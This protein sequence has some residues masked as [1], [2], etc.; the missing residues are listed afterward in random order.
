MLT[1][2]TG[3]RVSWA[4]L[5]ATATVVVLGSLHAAEP[6][7]RTPAP[8]DLYGD[9][10]PP[11]ALKRLGTLRFRYAATAIAYSPDG[12]LLA[13][14][15]ADNQIRLFDAATGRETRRLAG[16]QARTFSPVQDKKGAFDLLVGSVGKGHVTT[17]A[18]AP[19]G[20]TLASGAWDETIRLWDVDSG[21]ELRRLDGHADGMVATVTFSTDSKTLASRGGN[22][23]TV[24]LWEVATGK[25]L[26]VISKVQRVNPWRFNRDAALAFAPDG[27]TLAVG[28]AKVIQFLDVATGKV[29]A[30][31]DAH[32]GCTCLAYSADGKLLASGGVDGNDKHS[33][34]IWDVESG[35]ELR[36]CALVKDEPPISI[37]FS[38]DGRSLAAVVEEDQMT[39]FDV[40][41]GKP[42]RRLPQYWPSRLAYSPDGKTLA[43][44]GGATIRL[45]DPGTGKERGL[46]FEGH[47]AGVS[48]LALA[49]D[50][51]LIVSG[52]ENVRLWDP[53]TGKLVRT[54]PA[55]GAAIAL[56]PDG[57]T[58]ATAG[59]DRLVHLWDVGTGKETRQLTG[60]KHQLKGVAFSPDGNVLA[61]AD[62]QATVRLWDVAA[63]K[64]L[65]V[66][67]MKSLAETLSFAFSPDGKALACAGAW[68]DSSFLPGNFNIQGVEVT[69]KKG[70]LVLLWD[71]ATG[72][73]IRRFEGL[74]DKVRSV[75][76][77]PD[78]KKLAAA[79]RD[80][81]VCLWDAATGNELL[82]IMAHPDTTDA[83]FAGA[84]CVAFSPD[85]KH[86]A[87]AG[88]DRTVRLWDATT[89]REL[90]RFQADGAVLALAFTADGKE[91]VSGDADTAVI[92]WDLTHSVPPGKPKD[93]TIFIGD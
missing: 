56:A 13:A 88:S 28:D 63:G 35:K 40:D 43:V 26:S 39:V 77:S 37:A 32:P 48:S 72:K 82:F 73:E 75:A 93:N 6:A 7:A 57:N 78:G 21:K 64:E 50:G 58:L 8:A 12:K 49:A 69:T 24:R 38:P 91:L 53:A 87:S 66:I 76:F 23:G 42:A 16:H 20:K 68:D 34:R 79:A 90:M 25:L 14:G 54:I 36:R 41:T 60:H 33:L 65:Q 92:V 83:A 74:R 17:V 9:P 30:T 3:G 70:Y 2:H 46:E 10:M 62:A 67:D 22:D 61:S 44:A 15:G 81:Q 29:R 86:V 27:K 18:F 71:P 89:A 55:A 52:G 19:D 59:R 47:E 80:G 11:G 31:W 85:G 5:L 45:W 84:P 1:Q 51:K 4:W